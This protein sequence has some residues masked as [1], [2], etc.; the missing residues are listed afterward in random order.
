MTALSATRTEGRNW[1]E[2]DRE[3]GGEATERDETGLIGGFLMPRTHADV[4]QS[5]KPAAALLSGG[6]METTTERALE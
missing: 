1:R 6:E 4:P 5:A 3:S 2:K